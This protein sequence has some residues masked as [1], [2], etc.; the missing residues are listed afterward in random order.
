MRRAILAIAVFSLAACSQQAGEEFNNVRYEWG[1]ALVPFGAIPLYPMH[2]NIYPG[3]ILLYVPDVCKHPQDAVTSVSQIVWLGSIPSD[4]IAQLYARIY[5]NRPVLPETTPK[6]KTGDAGTPAK[7]PSSP[8]PQPKPLAA[9]Q[10]AGSPAA[11]AAAKAAA[12]PPA[13]APAPGGAQPD[14]TTAANQAITQPTGQIF[15]NSDAK[16]DR[17]RLAA[18]PALTIKTSISASAAGGGPLAGLTRLFGGIGGDKSTSRMVSFAQVEVAE[19]PAGPFYTTARNFLSSSAAQDMIEPGL[20]QYY[21]EMLR[22]NMANGGCTTEM[23]KVEPL[24][25]LINRVYYARQ[26]DFDLG[27]SSDFAAVLGAT[28]AGATAATKNSG[29]GVPSPNAAAGGGSPAPNASASG[30]DAQAA[31][32]ALAKALA[33]AGSGP[34]GVNTALAI[35]SSGALTLKVTFDRPLAF[36]A[37]QPVELSLHQAYALIAGVAPNGWKGAKGAEK[38]D[39][40]PLTD[41][42]K[43]LYCDEANNWLHL[44]VAHGGT[45]YDYTHWPRTRTLSVFPVDSGPLA[46]PDAP[47]NPAKPQP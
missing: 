25:V 9:G 42:K 8:A 45:G 47:A 18:F 43:H 2:E 14:T 17:L 10:S 16:V 13:K 23:Q 11:K 29:G 36:M 34:V 19:L 46:I 3:D 4:Q 6:A 35:G 30:T 22:R 44:P 12:K 7:P 39:C 32:Q 21:A 40:D 20:V 1:K 26:I 24:I 15:P 33:G 27:D 31:A 37:D 5:G 41:E 28:V 38:Y